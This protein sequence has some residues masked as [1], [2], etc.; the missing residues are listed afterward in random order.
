MDLG[1]L[2][3]PGEQS[4]DSLWIWHPN[5]GWLWT[6]ESV[7]PFLFSDQFQSWVYF[8][9]EREGNRIYVYNFEQWLSE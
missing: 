1:W 7:F 8:D 6:G 5:L 3:I 4:L 9:P 2:Y